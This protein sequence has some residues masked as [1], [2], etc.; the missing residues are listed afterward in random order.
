MPAVVNGALFGLWP[1]VPTLSASAPYACKGATSA[2]RR[3]A[4]VGRTDG[5]P[6]L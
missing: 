6:G 4:P 2:E 1:I 3:A 5:T